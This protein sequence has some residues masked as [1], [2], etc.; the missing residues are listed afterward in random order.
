MYIQWER[1]QTQTVQ[2]IWTLPGH[3]KL[4]FL[5]ERKRWTV[6]TN[7]R[8][9]ADSVKTTTTL[10]WAAKQRNAKIFSFI[11]HHIQSKQRRSAQLYQTEIPTRKKSDEK[12]WKQKGVNAKRNNLLPDFVLLKITL[13]KFLSNNRRNKILWRRQR[14]KINKQI[15]GR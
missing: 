14:R 13:V 6:H 12:I 2:N 5:T 4:P 7:D 1:I 9:A 8:I 15:R 10:Q 11:A 3:S